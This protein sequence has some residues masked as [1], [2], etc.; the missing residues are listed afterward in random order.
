MSFAGSFEDG[1]DD[2][3][4]IDL[5]DRQSIEDLPENIADFANVWDDLERHEEEQL[6]EE[7]Q[8]LDRTEW[9]EVAV[10]P[11]H[12]GRYEVTTTQ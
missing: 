2:Y 12:V 9:F 10:N 4:E 11:A 5:S 6:E 7:L 3:Y 1:Y 8:E